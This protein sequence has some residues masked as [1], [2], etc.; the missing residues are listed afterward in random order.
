MKVNIQYQDQSGRWQHYLMMNHQA[1]AFKTA[2][3]RAKST[4]KRHRLVDESG[5]LLDLLEP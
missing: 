3:N 1:N 2:Q 4:G 5:N